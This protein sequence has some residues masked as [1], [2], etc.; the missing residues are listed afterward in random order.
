MFISVSCLALLCSYCIRNTVPR[1]V[2][3]HG[4]T[5]GSR[6]V[7]AHAEEPYTSRERQPVTGHRGKSVSIGPMNCI[8]LVTL[9]RAKS[10]SIGLMFS[11]QLVTGQRAKSVS[12][13]PVYC[14]KQLNRV[15]VRYRRKSQSKGHK[16]RIKLIPCRETEEN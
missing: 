11:N 10:V 15:A 3:S 1:S 6:Q 2:R 12:I 5:G 13:V 14:I 8:Q 9:H 4:G 16:R 7:S